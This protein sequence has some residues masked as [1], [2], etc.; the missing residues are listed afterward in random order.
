MS[1]PLPRDSY[2]DW[3]NPYSLKNWI[4]SLDLY[5]GTSFEIGLFGSFFF[6][7]YLCSC[8]VFPPLADIYGRKVFVIAVCIE[9]GLCFLALL[10]VPNIYVFYIAIFIFGTSVPLKNMI[11]YTHIMEF[12]PGRVTQASGVL[13]FL[14][15]MILVASPL[16][17]MY[18]TTNTDIFLWFGVIQ[19]IVGLAGFIVMYIPEST[20]F[21]LEKER[22]K[23]ARSDIEYLLKFNK[24]TEGARV[25]CLSLLERYETKKKSSVEKALTA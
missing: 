24:A 14:D 6:F 17:V 22:F 1:L 11:A 25:S 9:Q 13:F 15:G 10:F 8:L 19:N 5:C 4:I 12:L 23:E 20:I 16:A 2:I 18:I 7:G 3:S 21:L